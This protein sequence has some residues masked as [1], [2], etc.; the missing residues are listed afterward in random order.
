MLMRQIYPP[1]D[2]IKNTTLFLVGEEKT[3]TETK[4]H[5]MI[6]SQCSELFDL[7]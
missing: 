4:N 2:F 5:S 3:I 7:Y 1:S 6:L